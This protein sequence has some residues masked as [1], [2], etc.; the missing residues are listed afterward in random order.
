MEL[1][2]VALKSR[3]GEIEIEAYEAIY[4]ASLSVKKFFDMKFA[5]SIPFEL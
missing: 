1:E 5:E 4:N 2:L 3:A